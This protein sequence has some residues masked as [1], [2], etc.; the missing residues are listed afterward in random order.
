MRRLIRATLAGLK[1]RQRE[2]VELSLRHHL[3][4]A[5]LAVVLG[6]S[7]SRA[8]ALSSRARSQLENALRVL[9]VTRTG[10]EDVSVAR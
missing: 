9:L 6:M 7:W 8:H 5:D 3:N 4:D 2:V 1:P 10:R